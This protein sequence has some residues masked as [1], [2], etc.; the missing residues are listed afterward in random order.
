MR[1]GSSSIWAKQARG[2][3]GIKTP[4]CYGFALEKRLESTVVLKRSENKKKDFVGKDI[5]DEN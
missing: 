1:A 3:G 4:T 2:G 5:A